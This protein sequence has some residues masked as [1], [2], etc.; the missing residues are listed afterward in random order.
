MQTQL[1]STRLQIV[2][3]DSVPQQPIVDLDADLR[4]NRLLAAVAARMGLNEDP[5]SNMRPLF[6]MEQAADRYYMLIA[7]A[8]QTLVGKFSDSD[9]NKLLNSTCAPDWRLNPGYRLVDVLMNAAGLERQSLGHAD[10]EFFSLVKKLGRLTFVQ[11]ASLVDVCERVW[12]GYD[13]S[14]L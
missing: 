14:L 4:T 2:L 5:C 9:F 3:N 10:A 1:Q 12:R 7:E 13:N 11:E 6:V 8:E